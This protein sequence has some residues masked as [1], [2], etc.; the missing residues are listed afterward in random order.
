MKTVRLGRTGLEVP[1]LGLGGIPLQRPAEDE[2]VE[3]VRAALDIGVRLIDTARGYGTSGERIGKALDGHR[4][5]GVVLCTKSPRRD[6]DGM[7]QA[8]E[9]S[10]RN[11]RAEC[12]DLYQCHGT[13]SAEQLDEILAPGGAMEALRKAQDEGLVRFVGIT[14][15]QYDALEAAVRTDEFDTLMVQYSFMDTPARERVFPLAREGDVG[16]L[17]MKCMGGGVFERP[18]PP[19]RW[20]LQEP[21]V[22][23]PVG[24][25]A[26]GEVEENWDIVSG[27][28]TLTD[29]DKLYIETLRAELGETFCRRCGYCMP[30]KNQVSIPMVMSF[31]MLYQRLGWRDN[32]PK[33]LESARRCV[34]C[35]EC[36]D[37]CPYDLAIATTVP[38]MAEE[39]A[40]VV[41]QHEAAR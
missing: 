4:P 19:L 24:M 17:L 32:Y 34:G 13:R 9:T 39:I 30:C 22:A 41:A 7:R 28:W 36:E 33:L 31:A 10:L 15:H 14:S 37:K 29:A 5:E 20:V 27:D 25:Q 2:A 18:G 11:L 1:V 12:I 3:V 26:V 23:L 38:K 6:A 35:Q 16:I 8:I 21:D 40:Q